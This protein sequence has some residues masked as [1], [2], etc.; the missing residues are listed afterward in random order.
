MS[1][2]FRYLLGERRRYLVG[3]AALA[4]TNVATAGI[5]YL[6]KLAIDTLEGAVRRGASILDDDATSCR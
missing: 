3:V 2:L 4:L 1:R 5:P 6:T